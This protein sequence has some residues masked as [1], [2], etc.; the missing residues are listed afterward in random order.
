M[1]KHD[2][3]VLPMTTAWS[4]RKAN[5]LGLPLIKS[6][7]P[8]FLRKIKAHRGFDANLDLSTVET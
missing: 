2:T 8:R 3:R 6:K 4:G 7:Y 1:A 5:Q